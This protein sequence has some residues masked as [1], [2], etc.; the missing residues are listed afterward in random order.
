MG[1]EGP[2]LTFSDGDLKIGGVSAESIAG[3]YGTPVYVTDIDRVLERYAAALSALRARYPNSL[4]AFAYK[5]NST[6]AV[7]E[8]LSRRGG[9]ATVVSLSGLKLALGC[10]VSPRK[11]VF[12]GPSKSREELAAAIKAGVGM[13]NAESTQ[14][15]LEIESLCARLKA[16][17]CRVGFRVNL[18][19]K[20]DTHA[21]LATGSSEHK[22]GVGREEV[23]RFCKDAKLARAKIFGLHSHIGSQLSDPWA[24]RSQTEELLS[25]AMELKES[26]VQIRE[27]NLGGGLGVSYKRGDEAMTFDA[28]ADATAGTFARLCKEPARLVFELGRSIVADSTIL[29][30]R[31]NYLKR[32][33]STD[34]A[35]VDAGMNDFLRPALYGAYHEIVP[36]HTMSRAPSDKGY[37]IGGPVCETSDVF[38]T[39]R[40]IGVE[41]SRGDLLAILDVGAYGISMAS[42]Y[43]MRPL[44][45]TIVVHHGR[46]FP[47]S[48]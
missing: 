21:G 43:N 25:L 4:I 37:S 19:I 12:D 1:H 16:R 32:M 6:K 36:A 41:L 2:H 11:V 46:H 5:S 7:V 28:Y 20:V 47:T 13:I 22:F 27:F 24:F 9:G 8:A 45:A 3:R 10:G 44:P 15:V 26:G 23:V 33:G 35:L 30:T 14:E 39:G 18:G 31:V 34:W 42:T 48:S 17:S 29:L 38:G 40:R